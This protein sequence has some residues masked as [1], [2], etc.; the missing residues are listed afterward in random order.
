MI[1]W[2]SKKNTKPIQTGSEARKKEIIRIAK[3]TP[4]PQEQKYSSFN[5]CLDKKIRNYC[6][7]IKKLKGLSKL[8]HKLLRQVRIHRVNP[9]KKYNYLPLK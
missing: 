4:L 8:N 9:L 1:L 2:E 6:K 5:W 3:Q 7:R